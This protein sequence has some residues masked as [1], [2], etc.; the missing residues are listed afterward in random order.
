MRLAAAALLA[1]AARWVRLARLGLPAHPGKL[2]A[3][4]VAVEAIRERAQA[5]P[6]GRGDTLGAA[7][8]AEAAVKQLAQL[9]GVEQM[10]G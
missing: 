1:L 3:G 2:D 6:A 4:A 9:A 5:R 8:A 7:E 10:A